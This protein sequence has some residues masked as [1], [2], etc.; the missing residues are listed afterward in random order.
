MNTT[1]KTL[2]QEA[3]GWWKKLTA[4]YDIADEAGLLLLQTGLE[5]FDRMRG[6]Q[7]QIAVE[8]ATLLDRF[9]QQKPHPL[10]SVERDARAQLMQAMKALNLDVEI[11]PAAGPGRPPGS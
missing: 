10:L 8:G 1:P 6:C 3:A 9:G 11:T 7:E 2:S 4:E 5:S